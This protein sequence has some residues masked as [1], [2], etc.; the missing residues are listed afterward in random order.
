MT[1]IPI[2]IYPD[3]VLREKA[4]AVSTFTP[5]LGELL[6]N[7]AETMYHGDGIGLAGPQV[8]ALQR[9]IVV[10]VSPD[11]SDLI[12]FVNPEITSSEGTTS[13]EEGCLSIPG[14]RETVKRKERIEVKAL[15]R[16]GKEFT[17]EADGIKAI[18]IQHEIDHLN[19][20]LFVDHLSR[21]K[22]ELFKRW[23]RKQQEA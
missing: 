2:R 16:E 6:D 22:R 17:L 8:A 19:G 1:E 14:F 18:C 20:V 13:S 4:T 9:V 23:H 7:M 21:L 5:E 15:T 3:P 12:E 11:R 10:D